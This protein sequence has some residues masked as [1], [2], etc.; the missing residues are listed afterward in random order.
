MADSLS[1]FQRLRN[2]LHQELRPFLDV[3][4]YTNLTSQH[5][6]DVMLYLRLKVKGKSLDDLEQSN[7]DLIPSNIPDQTKQLVRKI[8]KAMAEL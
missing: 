4:S 5:D 1:I 8:V 6:E 2:R 7:S 3:S